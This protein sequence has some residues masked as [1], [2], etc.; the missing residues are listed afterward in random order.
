VA[1]G[2]FVLLYHRI[3]DVERDP[4]RLAVRPAHFAE[5]CR[6]LRKLCEVVPLGN[7]DRSLRQVVITF[8]D[9]YADNAHQARSILSAA[10]LPATFFITIGR[11][12]QSKEVWWDR[13]EQILLECKSD[14]ESIEID[15]GDRPI[16]ADIRSARAR[17]RAHEALYWRLLPLPPSAIEAALDVI[18]QRLGVSSTYRGIN[19]WMSL[20][21][22][23]DLASCEGMDIGAHTLTHPFLSK[24]PAAEQ[25]REIDGSRQHLQELLGIPVNLFAYP[26]GG[27]DAFDARTAMMVRDAGYTAACTTTGGLTGAETDVYQIPRNV[28]GDWDGATF[29][30]WLEDRFR[31]R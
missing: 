17:E 5:H 8:D 7:L 10:G 12:E 24:L 4:Y 9:G 2:A 19:R 14:A 6:I 15:L 3:I 25:W 29:E 18:E 31:A 23:R 27:Q 30:A 11:L 26:Y 21:E 13:L 1:A 22:L 16:W 28:V 20:D